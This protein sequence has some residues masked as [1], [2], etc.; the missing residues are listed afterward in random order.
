MSSYQKKEERLQ[1]QQNLDFSPFKG[2]FKST[3]YDGGFFN[4]FGNFMNSE[5][6]GEPTGSDYGI[7]FQRI[8]LVPRHPTQR[9]EAF[10]YLTIFQILHWV[11]SNQKVKRKDG[12]IFGLFIVLLFGVRFILEFFKINQVD[13]ENGMILNIGQLLSIP[14]ILSGIGL[15]AWKRIPVYNRR[16]LR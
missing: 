6:I 1:E 9:Y 14:F 12:Y 15:I 16:R 10:S 3:F 4:R 8:D 13:F 5:N 7:V 11:Y 2:L